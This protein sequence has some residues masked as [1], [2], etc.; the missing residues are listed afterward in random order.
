[1]AQK[2]TLAGDRVRLIEL[3][4]ADHF[5]L[6]DST[7]AAWKTTIAEIHKLQNRM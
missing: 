2:A 7:S 4:E 3:A 6:I 5:A 1:M